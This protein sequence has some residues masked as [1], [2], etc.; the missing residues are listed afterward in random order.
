MRGDGVHIAFDDDDLTGIAN[1]IFRQVDSINECALV[2][3]ERL[4]GIQVFWLGITKGATAKT[5]DIAVAIAD[6]EHQ[7]V[8]EPVVKPAGIA[9]AGEPRFGREFPRDVPRCQEVEEAIP[10]FRSKAERECV[11]HVV[12]DAS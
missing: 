7:P 3:D 11:D 8:A 2:E 9:L 5:D 1:R 10:R 6:W 12:R 4:W